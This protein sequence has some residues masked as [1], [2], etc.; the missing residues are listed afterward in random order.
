MMAYSFNSVSKVDLTIGSRFQEGQQIDLNMLS[1]RAKYSTIFRKNTFVVGLDA[2]D[3]SYTKTQKTN[4]T[5]A[6]FQII[7]KFKILSIYAQ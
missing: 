7:K 4:Y 1:A 6:Y 3:R 5:G 2:Y